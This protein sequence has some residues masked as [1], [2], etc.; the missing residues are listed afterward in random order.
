MIQIYVAY[1]VTLYI[2]RNKQFESKRLEKVH[3]ANSNLKRAE[4]L[5]LI[6]DKINFKAKLFL[7][8]KE[9]IYDYLRVRQKRKM[10]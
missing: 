1:K 5:I 2:Q 3:H 7:E 4:V 6:S 10:W 8:K 9:D